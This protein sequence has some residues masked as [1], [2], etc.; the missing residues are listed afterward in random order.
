MEGVSQAI[1][2]QLDSQ[3]C[4]SRI[5]KVENIADSFRLS[6]PHPHDFSPSKGDI[7]WIPEVRRAIIDGTDEEF[8]NC[9]AGLRSRIPELSVAW[10]EERRKVFLQLLP[11]DSPSLEHFSLVTTLFDCTECPTRGM[12]IETAL[13]HGCKRGYGWRGNAPRE[14][15]SNDAGASTFQNEADIPWD[16]G[17]VKFE[18]SAERS[19]LARE[20]ALECGEDPDTVTIQEMNRKH[21]RI[22]LFRED[23]TVAVLNWLQV[24]SSGARLSE[25]PT[26]DVRHTISLS[27][28]AAAV[29]HSFGSC[30]LTSYRNTYLNRRTWGLLGVASTAGEQGK[31]PNRVLNGL[32]SSKITL[33]V[34]KF[35]LVCEHMAYIGPSDVGTYLGTKLRT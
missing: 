8:Q 5:A 18:Y 1:H 10:L 23:G 24:V 9:E 13:S 27:S 17:H 12:R 28:S 2:D 31:C 3:R 4:E 30:G 11:Q 34:R 25:V 16:W 6:L 22:A 26:P 32:V 14:T 19:A 33:L 20:V 21:H 15:F 29:V 7:C 35:L